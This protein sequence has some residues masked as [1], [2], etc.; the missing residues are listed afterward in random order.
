MNKITFTSADGTSITVETPAG[1]F[2]FN[3]HVFKFPA[4]EDQTFSLMIPADG[5]RTEERTAAIRCIRVGSGLPFLPA[6]K[7]LSN[8]IPF[9]VPASRNAAFQRECEVLGI[10]F[11]KIA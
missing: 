8:G 2:E 5:T 6:Q 3:G 11:N 4:L 1:E 9:T 10:T 7:A